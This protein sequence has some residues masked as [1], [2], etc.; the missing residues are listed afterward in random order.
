MHTD[1]RIV[2]TPCGVRAVDYAN[3]DDHGYQVSFQSSIDLPYNMELDWGTQGVD[4]L[5]EP[6]SEF[7]VQGDARIAWHII[8][9]LELSSSGTYPRTVY[10][11]DAI[12]PGAARREIQRSIYLRSNWNY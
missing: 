4:R 2:G 5:P 3:D 1:L 9:A 8:P 10:H 6:V 11:V 7:Y 12:M